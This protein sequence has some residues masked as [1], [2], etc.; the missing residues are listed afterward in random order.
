MKEWE[1]QQE[2]KEMSAMGEALLGKLRVSYSVPNQPSQSCKDA[3]FLMSTP[4]D[5]TP[6]EKKK[7]RMRPDSNES[8]VPIECFLFAVCEFERKRLTP[9]PMRILGGTLE[10]TD[11]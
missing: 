2:M 6:L 4:V 1:Q 9:L 10:Q 11:G 5:A 8:F 3:L 7:D